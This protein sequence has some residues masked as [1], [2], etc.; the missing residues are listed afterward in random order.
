MFAGHSGDQGR[1]PRSARKRNADLS[2]AGRLNDFEVIDIDCGEWLRGARTKPIVRTNRNGKEVPVVGPDRAILFRASRT[3]F[4]S[5]VQLREG[6]AKPAFSRSRCPRPDNL[7]EARRDRKE[8][9]AYSILEAL[10]DPSATAC[11]TMPR[12]HS[13]WRAPSQRTSTTGWRSPNPSRRG[14]AHWGGGDLR[15]VGGLPSTPASLFICH[16][17]QIEPAPGATMIPWRSPPLLFNPSAIVC[18]VG[19]PVPRSRVSSGWLVGMGRLPA[20][21]RRHHR[22]PTRQG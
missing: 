7:P 3:A 1:H 20:G 15:A 8:K 19:L 5:M 6:I 21:Y 17:S 2:G 11:S 16:V 10:H 12:S 18:R 14:G 9:E 13:S 4:S 22:G